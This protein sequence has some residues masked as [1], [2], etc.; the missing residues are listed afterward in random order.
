MAAPQKYQ[1]PLAPLLDGL[2]SGPPPP[3][4]HPCGKERFLIDRAT[5]ALKAALLQPATREFNYDVLQ[6]KE[7]GA[8][9]I[10]ACVRTVPMMAK[11]RLVLVR[12][13]DEMSAD[14]L[15]GLLRYVEAPFPE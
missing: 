3:L 5:E 2:R 11:R 4:I 1:D 10:L 7:A 13:A 14:D 6:G 8:A 9:R 12:D 15:A